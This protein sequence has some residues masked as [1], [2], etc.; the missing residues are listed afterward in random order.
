MISFDYKDA[1]TVM[2]SVGTV[3]L[4]PEECGLDYWYRDVAGGFAAQMIGGRMPDAHTPDWM[5][6]PG[7]FR[8]ALIREFA[9]RAVAEE[10]A[11]RALGLLVDLAPTTA[12]MNFF[13][14]QLLDEARHAEAFRSHLA[15]L[16]GPGEELEETVRAQ[17]AEGVA[18][19]LDPLETFA[20]KHIAGADGYLR[21]VAILT[22]LV[23]GVLAPT[24]ELSERKWARIDP[25]AASVE[26]GAAIDEV[27]HLA[28]GSEIV[29][30]RFAENKACVE[31]T[32][33]EGMALWDQIPIDAELTIREGYFDEGLA[34]VRDGGPEHPLSKV[35]SDYE[36]WEGQRLLTSSAHDRIKTALEW[37]AEAQ[38]SRLA[39]M[40][41]AP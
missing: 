21:G 25:A 13:A 8:S 14:T 35:L 22:I 9:F 40:G 33:A 11:T 6:A 2:E 32:M 18:N 19:V 31:E 4:S 27:R 3:R 12:E 29:R 15:E 5:M 41:V 20:R 17:A 30:R 38:A 16:L 28:V 39:F 24:G 34:Q 26:R 10:R 1:P 7:P 37:S 36:V 23:E